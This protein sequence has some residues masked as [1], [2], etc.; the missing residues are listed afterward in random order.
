[1]FVSSAVA[2]KRVIATVNPNDTA[3]NGDADIYDPTTGSVVPTAGKMVAARAQFVAVRMFGGEVFVAGGYNNRYLRLVEIYDPSTGTFRAGKNPMLAARGGAVATLLQGGTILVAGGYNGNYLS[4][5]EIYDPTTETFT[6]AASM[7]VARQNATATR[8]SGGKILIAGGFNGAFLNTSEIYTTSSSSFTASKGVMTSAREGHA[9]T[10]LADGRVLITGGC[11][12][13][14]SAEIRCDRFL[15]SAEIYE[16]STDSYSAT[17]LMSTPRLN[18]TATLLTDGTVLIA[19]GSDG[20]TPLASA[21]IFDPKTG[22]FTAVSGLA[23]A[24]KNHTASI[25]PDGRVL[26]AGGEADQ[27]LSSIEIFDL[28]SGAF[29]TAAPMTVPRSGHVATELADGS[30]LLVGG[31]NAGLLSFDVN[32][33]T[34]IDNIS[35]NIVFSADSKT[36]FVP[37]AGSGVVLAF[38]AETGSV[39]RKIVTG[40]R[41]AFLTPLPDGN[42]L[43]V[44]SVL[45]NRIFTI[46][47]QSLTLKDTYTFTGFFGF[48]SLMTLSPDNSKGY[49]SSTITGEVI[50]F[51][52]SNFSELGRLT[53]MRGPAQITVTKDGNTLLIVDVIANEVV[54]ADASTMTAKHKV[55]LIDDF[56]TASLTISNKAVLNADETLGIIASHDSNTA[57]SCT[58]NAAFVFNASSGKILNTR[59]ITCY[60]GSTILLPNGDHWVV[61]GQSGISVISTVSDDYDDDDDGID[62][63]HGSGSVD[64]RSDDYQDTVSISGSTLGSANLLLSEDPRYVY[65]GV[66][67]LDSVYQHDVDSHGVV[68]SF[69]VGDDPNI[70]TDQ[71]VAVAATPD[72]KILAAL[73]FASNELVLLGDVTVSRQTKYVNRNDEFTG[74]SLVNLSDMNT[75]N[76]S[77][78][79]LAN[80][81][82]EQRDTK[83]TLD[84]SDDLVNPVTVQLAPNAQESVDI[85]ELFGLETDDTNVGRLLIETDQPTIAGFSAT[86]KIRSNFFDPYLRSLVG[87]PLYTDYRESLHDFIIPEI[88]QDTNA[89]VELNLVNP[90][91]NT[92]FYDATHYAED[93]IVMKS[94]KNQSLAGSARSARTVSEFLLSAIAG[95]VIVAGGYDSGKTRNNAYLFTS[96]SSSFS[97]TFGLTTPRYGHTAALLQNEQILIAGGRNG[98][99]VLRNA[100]IYHPAE[101]YFL[102]AAGTMNIAR[103][104]HSATRLPN[105][106]VLI[107][108][109]QNA[110]SYNNTA[111][112]YDSAEGSFKLLPG[113][114]T[115]ARDSHTATLLDTGKVLL[116]GGIDGISITATAEV[117]DPDTE[118]F[119]AAGSMS[120]ARVFHTAVALPNGKVLIAGGYNGSYL[121]SAE[122]FDPATGLFSPTTPMNLERSNHTATLLSDGTVLIVGGKNSSGPLSS[123]EIYNP[124]SGSFS[125]VESIMTSSRYSHTATLL[126]DDTDGANDKVLIV[127]GFGYNSDDAVDESNYSE[128]TL[129]AA[130]LYNPA[131]QRFSNTAGRLSKAAQGHTATLL[132]GGGQGHLRIESKI[133]LLFTEIFDRGGT[134]GSLNGINVDKYAGITKIYSPKFAITSDF[135]TQVNIINANQVSGATVTLTLHSANGSVLAEPASFLIPI[136]GQIKGNLM[137]LFDSNPS[138]QDQV[139]WLEVSS[140]ADRI[141]GTVTFT[142]ANNAFLASYELSGTPLGNF[143]YPLIAHDSTYQTEIAM[144]NS[145]SQTA[146]A[147][148]ELWSLEGTLDAFVSLSIAPGTS[149][150]KPLNEIFTGMQPH[151]PGNV[152]IRSSQPLHSFATIYTSDLRFMTSE[153]PVPYPETVLG[154]R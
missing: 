97:E 96:S 78:S 49:I 38:S 3:L 112:L 62:D 71:T 92:S 133:G 19:G 121:N 36:G 115:S 88:P 70:V 83:G 137:S 12:N 65:Y 4:S 153:P 91:Y 135:L 15:D 130:E 37:Y 99:T 9:A 73:N 68:G 139:G 35:P 24:R 143:I 30:I 50:K 90:N 107:A 149:I 59:A 103:Y 60:P 117:Y 136:N 25:L 39:I 6:S 106:K 148:L 120:A 129:D 119:Q 48:G 47:M 114:M 81:G 23:S 125:L 98:T 124:F 21:E 127:G 57:T 16:P 14:N 74:L 110:R 72:W 67:S 79:L 108:G 32:S 22:T 5:A 18:H 86:G 123:G 142:N 41:P 80:D 94:T 56:P 58:V 63:N 46:D 7:T 146:N 75:A 140:S 20:A 122:L 17:G 89:S 104:R 33:Q 95:R 10:L 40:G 55:T 54:L 84:P 128:Q 105:G 131:T 8:L 152:R 100:E 154:P 111:E 43:A 93:G 141:V 69:P 145:G 132:G 2:Q 31:E 42:T 26:I 116:A 150:A 77:I 44:V 29:T 13:T 82:T 34:P 151:R 87:I 45:D 27:H 113:L 61:L 11:N 134:P 102:P 85:S 66:A 147:E 64:D 51:D 28:A 109:G 52:V 1:M 118:T 53:G 76:V 138:L 101:N 144:L 126:N